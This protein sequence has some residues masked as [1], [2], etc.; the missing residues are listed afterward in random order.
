MSRLGLD[1]LEKITGK[2]QPCAQARW[3]KT[4][5]GVDV[6]YDRLGAIIT[7]SAFDALVFRKLG[8]QTAIPIRPQVKLAHKRA[9]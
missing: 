3:F 7:D 9:A 1:R 5:F 6:G 8:L 2:E 4:Y